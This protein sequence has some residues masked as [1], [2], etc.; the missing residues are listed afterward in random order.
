LTPE[1]VLFFLDAD[2]EGKKKIYVLDC[3]KE[4]NILGKEAPYFSDYN[5]YKSRKWNNKKNILFRNS[6]Q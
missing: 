6:W 3:K 4:N 2:S 1:R 5:N